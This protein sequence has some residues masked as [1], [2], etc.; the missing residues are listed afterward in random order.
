M[1]GWTVASEL[2]SSRSVVWCVGIGE[3]ISFDLAI[4]AA[5]GMPID[6]FDPTPRSLDWVRG[7]PLPPDYRV[8]PYGLADRDGEVSFRP[9]T[10]PRH[11]SNSMASD[12][13]DGASVCCDLWDGDAQEGALRDGVQTKRGA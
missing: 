3:D 8:H 2:L 6:A 7:Q 9:P 1:A 10:D 11:V 13:A 4:H 12:E 5:Y